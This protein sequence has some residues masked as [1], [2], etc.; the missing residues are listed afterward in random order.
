LKRIII[1]IS[2]ALTLTGCATF[3]ADVAKIE[4]VFTLAS[5]TTVPAN[6]AIVAANSYDV[7]V[8][9]ATEFLKYCKASPA[10]T[11]CSA[12]V[13]RSIIQY[14]RQGRSAR[15]QIESAGVTG[16]PISSTVYNLVV[17]AVNSL[18]ASPASTFGASK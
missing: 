14:V 5:T 2:L 10:D 6:V 4:K 7:L 13:R 12:N 1:A 16:Q 3:N 18:T 15:N 11:R 17:Q 9:G 8:A